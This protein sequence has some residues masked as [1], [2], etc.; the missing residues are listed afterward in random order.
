MT[1]RVDDDGREYSR[2]NCR[3]IFGIL[4]AANELR[5]VALEEKAE[6]R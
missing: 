1:Y 5:V 6:H 3:P 4:L 2:R